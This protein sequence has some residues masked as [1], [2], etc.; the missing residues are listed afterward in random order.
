MNYSIKMFLIFLIDLKF[1]FTALKITL[2]NWKKI[3]KLLFNILF[4]KK[5]F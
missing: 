5:S 2:N 1:N 3:L 4:K